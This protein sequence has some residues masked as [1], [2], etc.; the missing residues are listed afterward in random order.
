MLLENTERSDI[1]SVCRA[2]IGGF[3]PP[4]IPGLA[5]VTNHPDPKGVLRNH[6]AGKYR[7]QRHIFCMQS[8]NRRLSPPRHS[9][10]SDSNSSLRSKKSPCTS[11][12]AWASVWYYASLDF[13]RTKLLSFEY[14]DVSQH[15]AYRYQW[16]RWS[17]SLL[18]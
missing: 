4:P 7:A 18:R 16:P 10:A 3:S 15:N 1:F 2:R 6:V 9:W 8:P 17:Q 11:S 14:Q 13:C 12:R 5:I